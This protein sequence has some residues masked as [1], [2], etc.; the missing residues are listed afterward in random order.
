MSRPRKL[1]A[2]ARA[3]GVGLP[4]VHDVVNAYDAIGFLESTR[5]GAPARR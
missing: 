1:D 5:A 4:E 2:I 3:C